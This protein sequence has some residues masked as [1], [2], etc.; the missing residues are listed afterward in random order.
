MVQGRLPWN[1]KSGSKL[2]KSF[3]LF[4]WFRGA[5]LKIKKWELTL[6]KCVTLF[7]WFRGAYLKIKKWELTL[8]KCSTVLMVQGAYLK[9]KKWELTLKKC[10]TVL[11]IQGRLPWNQKSGSEHWKVLHCSDGSGAPTLPDTWWGITSSPGL[12][13]TLGKQIYVSG[14][15]KRG[16]SWRRL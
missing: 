16:G 5:Y 2:W 7:W 3:T 4:W 11:M 10:Y 8:K 14:S 6:K 13:V 15:E 12:A 9:I 1:Q